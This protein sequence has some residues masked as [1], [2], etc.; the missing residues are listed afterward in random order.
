MEVRERK[1]VKLVELY[2]VVTNRME[3]YILEL[4]LLGK[5]YY[6]AVYKAV[7]QHNPNM[8]FAVKVISLQRQETR[9]EILKELEIIRSIPKSPNLVDTHK[10]H[11]ES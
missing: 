6:G 4:N 11:L 9:E 5:G 10:Q 3:P 2:D 7:H 1:N 8:V